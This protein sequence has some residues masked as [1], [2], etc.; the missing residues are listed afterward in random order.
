MQ[1]FFCAFFIFFIS[2]EIAMSVDRYVKNLS[3][4]D[5]TVAIFLLFAGIWCIAYTE[6]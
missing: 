1:R 4:W 6:K 5:L 2:L 3:I